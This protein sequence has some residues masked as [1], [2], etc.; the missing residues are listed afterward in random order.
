MAQP[1]KATAS[2]SRARRPNT[3]GPP[4]HA[5]ARPNTPAPADRHRLGCGVSYPGRPFWTCIAEFA[6]SARLL[7]EIRTVALEAVA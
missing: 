2:P 5:G 4:E 1:R 7:Y 3:P 6:P